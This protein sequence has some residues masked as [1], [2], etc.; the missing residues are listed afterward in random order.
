[1]FF[2]KKRKND[3]S[4]IFSNG[5]T[6]VAGDGKEA[7]A[8]GTTGAVDP[9]AVLRSSGINTDLIPDSLLPTIASSFAMNTDESSDNAK[10]KVDCTSCN[11]PVAY[12]RGKCMYCGKP[13][14][15]PASAGTAQAADEAAGENPAGATSLDIDLGESF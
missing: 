7:G 13:L 4:E 12:G 8:E 6:P 3:I 1:M 15:L 14:E 11:R 10:I 2:R 9:L 5:S